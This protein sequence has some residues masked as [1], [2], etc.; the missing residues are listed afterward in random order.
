METVLINFILEMAQKYPQLTILFIVMGV[1]RVVFKP[2]FSF[3][4]VVAEATPSQADNILL[5][6]VQ[7]SKVYKAV[8]WFL[9]Y[10]ASVKL[11]GYDVKK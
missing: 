5:D 4:R 10:I 11:P 3:L 7:D 2:L 9:D 6:K 8:A 1:L